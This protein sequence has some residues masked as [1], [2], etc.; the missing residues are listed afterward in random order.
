MILPQGFAPRLAAAVVK[1]P[2]VLSHGAKAGIMCYANAIHN[3]DLPIY[4]RLTC[5]P[6]WSI[7]SLTFLGRHS[8]RRSKPQG[9]EGSIFF[10]STGIKK[11]F[12]LLNFASATHWKLPVPIYQC[13]KRL[14]NALT[15]RLQSLNYRYHYR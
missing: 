15:E 12:F 8:Q 14:N 9:L 1:C 7:M 13:L 11:N 5:A 10:I 6:L 3:V 2:L 4:K